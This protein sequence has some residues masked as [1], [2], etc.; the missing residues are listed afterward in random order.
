M[1][2]ELILDASATLAWLLQSVDP[3]EDQLANAVLRFANTADPLAPPLWYSG[4]ANGVLVTER[5]GDI[6]QSA[7]AAFLRIVEELPI[8]EDA[9][10]PSA[11]QPTILMLA[12]AY[13]LAGYDATYLEL[14]LR[15]GRA[16]ATFD[17]QLA[18]AVHEAGG[19]VFG[20]PA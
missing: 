13:K 14:V 9:T 11:V 16:L 4:V 10:R 18:G 6:S 5:R 2:M 12:R 7:S 3:I 19:R 17:R 8:L 15:T 1:S 20:D